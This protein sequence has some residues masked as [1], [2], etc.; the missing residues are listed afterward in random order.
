M[1]I[2][3]CWVTTEPVRNQPSRA[4]AAV[5]SVSLIHARLSRAT[6]TRLT[7]D[8]GG[9]EQL[10]DWAAGLGHKLTFATGGT[11]SYGSG[12]TGAVRRS[13]IGVI[14]VMRTD[15]RYRRLRGKSDTLDAENAARAALAGPQFPK[16]PMVLLK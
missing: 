16:A 2:V 13:G 15:R 3:C 6:A 1:R 9:C 8:S 5:R 14:E 7:A 11:G 4:R 10:T 12:L